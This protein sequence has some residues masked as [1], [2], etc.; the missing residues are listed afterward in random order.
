MERRGEIGLRRS[1]GAKPIHVAAQFVAESAILG[2]LGGV[3]G[4]ALGVGIVLT[5]AIVK[6]WTAIM[7]T[8]L[9]AA[10]LIG[11]AIGVVAGLYPAWR[12]TRIEPSQALHQ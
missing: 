7:P 5:S 4:T 9:L 10:P 6:Q 2:A 11:T 8:S 12:A 3:V 1:L